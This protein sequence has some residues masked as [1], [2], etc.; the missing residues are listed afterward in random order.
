MVELSKILVDFHNLIDLRLNFSECKKIDDNGLRE[1]GH[2]LIEVSHSL[3]T[4][5]LSFSHC[6]KITDQGIQSMGK[7]LSSIEK[8]DE[9]SL[10]FTNCPKFTDEGFSSLAMVVK[11]LDEITS[12]KLDFREC[13]K[14]TNN[15]LKIIGDKVFG[16]GM[17]MVLTHFDINMSGCP[18]ITDEGALCLANRLSHLESI[19]FLEMKFNNCLKVTGQVLTSLGSSI[20]RLHHKSSFQDGSALKMINL[21][22]SGCSNVIDSD[23]NY[24]SAAVSRLSF[25][26]CV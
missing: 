26:E 1:I 21:D 10:H 3:R 6:D 16:E 18:K 4:L 8:L 19:S 11:Q 13:P 5:K 9:L 23:L 7:S 14:I 2:A 22:L 12:L 25:L 20:L 24:F 15:S 17:M